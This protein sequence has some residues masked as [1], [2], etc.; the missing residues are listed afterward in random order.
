MET[1]G[2]ASSKSSNY[3]SQI[4]LIAIPLVSAPFAFILSREYGSSESLGLEYLLIGFLSLEFVILFLFNQKYFKINP[5]FDGDDPVLE[6]VILS[7]TCLNCDKQ[8]ETEQREDG[9]EVDCPYCET[10]SAI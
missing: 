6:I 3:L 9:D 5:I 1:R 2:M 10:S 7:L 4:L 8:F